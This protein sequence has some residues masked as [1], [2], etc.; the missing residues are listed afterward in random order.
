MRHH[1]L[2]ESSRYVLQVDFSVAEPLGDLRRRAAALDA[3]RRILA[4]A[5]EAARRSRLQDAAAHDAAQ[6]EVMTSAPAS[7]L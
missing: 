1:A 7:R 5:V 4:A 6:D 2:D 3:A